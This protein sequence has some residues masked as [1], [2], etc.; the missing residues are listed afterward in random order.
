MSNKQ[1]LWYK[2]P[3]QRFDIQTL[4]HMPIS[5]L[6]EIIVQVSFVDFSYVYNCL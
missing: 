3:I 6:K 4:F 5:R 1:I 2:N